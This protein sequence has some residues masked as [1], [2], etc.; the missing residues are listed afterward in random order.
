MII[1]LRKFCGLQGAHV[2]MSE[3]NNNGQCKCLDCV[4]AGCQSCQQY[5]NLLDEANR[6]DQIKLERCINCLHQNQR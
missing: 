5:K 3:H 6:K 1:A 2:V 4:G